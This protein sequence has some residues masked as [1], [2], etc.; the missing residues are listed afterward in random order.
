MFRTFLLLIFAAVFATADAAIRISGDSYKALTFQAEAAS[1]LNEILVLHDAS[2]AT[3][4]YTATSP[5]SR[6]T[7][8]RYG[9]RGG[10]FAEE[11][12]GVTYN[13]R[14]SSL[15]L[16]GDDAGY[17]VEDG[18]R[19]Y[20]FW[21]VNYSRHY[22]TIDGLRPGP[23]QDC[24]RASL[25][26]DGNAD[27][28]DYYGINGRAFVLS[29]EIP[30]TYQTLEFDRENFRYNQVERTDLLDDLGGTVRIQA[31]LC[32]TRFEI[33]EDRFMK[34]WGQTLEFTSD[35]YIALAVQ[36]ETE[37]VQ[38]ERDVPNEKKETTVPEGQLG[39]SAPCTITFNA[40]VTDAAV[41]REWQFSDDQEFNDIQLRI[42]DLSTEYVFREE[43]AK[44]V[45]FMAANNDGSCEYFSETYTVTIG[46]SELDCP[47]AFSPGASEG[48]NDEW[49]VSYKSIIEFDCHIFN[50]WG[51]EMAHLTDP[52]Q[53]WDGKYSGK[54]VPAGVYFYVVKAK[55]SDGKEYKLSGDIN[56]VN[57]K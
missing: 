43:G 23:E 50:R 34:A 54:V 31:P 51:L 4:T 3:A 49:R 14:E 35:T 28:I 10:G 45:R 55:G 56:V 17:I 16:S 20:Y 29:R 19:R 24:D 27:K 36:A 41:F 33:A 40:A 42:S 46:L 39:G 15:R 7:W 18:S 25:V 38:A 22:M 5:S 53:G 52:S 47:N 2:A 1:G 11:V 57:Y 8:Y 32:D 12:P 9:N 21:V 44:Y 26:V 37:A 30:I 6:P 13:G 48:V